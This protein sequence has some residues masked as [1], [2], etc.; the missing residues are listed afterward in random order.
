M[1]H[2][3]YEYWLKFE[4]PEKAKEAIAYY[5]QT[6]QAKYGGKFEEHSGLIV[7]YIRDEYQV[8]TDF[9]NFG[10][11]RFLVADSSHGYK[12]VEGKEIYEFLTEENTVVSFD[13][14]E[15][16]FEKVNSY[17]TENK[18]N[19]GDIIPVIKS[20]DE[21]FGMD[22]LFDMLDVDLPNHYDL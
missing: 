11:K 7:F 12:R 5:E 8:V 22:D 19:K 21:S 13:F 6:Y 2:R 20:F 18:Y 4:Q 15:R 10:L 16:I 9:Y 14:N 1:N 3:Y 17:L